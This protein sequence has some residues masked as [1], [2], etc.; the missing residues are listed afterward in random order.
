MRMIPVFSDEFTN[1]GVAADMEA[2][3]ADPAL[4]GLGFG[5]GCGGAVG[6]IGG[7]FDGVADFAAE[8]EEFF[9]G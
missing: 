4:G 2:D 7:E 9:V 6:E 3:V 1:R 8:L 5:V